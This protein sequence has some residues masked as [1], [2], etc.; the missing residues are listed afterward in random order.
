MGRN[1]VKLTNDQVDTILSEFGVTR[2]SDY[3]NN[4]TTMQV[5]CAAGHVT[6]RTLHSIRDGRQ[7]RICSGFNIHTLFLSGTASC[8]K[9][10]NI[11]RLMM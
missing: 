6:D 3:V 9:A 2:L 8:E 4:K 7:C 1:N 11:E 5:R 10:V